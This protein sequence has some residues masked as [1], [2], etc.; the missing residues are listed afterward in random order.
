MLQEQVLY[1]DR[2]KISGIPFRLQACGT[3]PTRPHKVWTIPVS[4]KIPQSF[5]G[6]ISRR[7]LI[8]LNCL[9]AM[10]KVYK[11]YSPG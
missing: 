5:S 7:V 8:D 3:G 9:Q 4:A 1:C 2:P 6:T 10:C 11:G